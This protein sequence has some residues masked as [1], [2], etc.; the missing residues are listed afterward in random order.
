MRAEEAVVF[1]FMA[2]MLLLGW[3]VWE[4]LQGIR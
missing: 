1:S 2:L 4:C 3:F